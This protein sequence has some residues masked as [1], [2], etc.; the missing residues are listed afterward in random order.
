MNSDVFDVGIFIGF[1]E[2]KVVFDVLIVQFIVGDDKI[3]KFCFFLI[4][5]NVLE[6]IIYCVYV[7]QFLRIFNKFLDEFDVSKWRILIEEVCISFFN[8]M[9]LVFVEQIDFQ[10]LF[11]MKNIDKYFMEVVEFG[12]DDDFWERFFSENIGDV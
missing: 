10:L 3:V 4:S 5:N 2:M 9:V 8:D 1:L 11:V 7:K 6:D 12:F